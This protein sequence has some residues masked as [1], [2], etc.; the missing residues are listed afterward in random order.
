VLNQVLLIDSTSLD[1]SSAD[2]GCSPQNQCI[3]L[4]ALWSMVILDDITSLDR[5]K[6]IMRDKKGI[7]S[8]GLEKDNPWEKGNQTKDA[9]EDSFSTNLAIQ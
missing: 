3:S 4:L 1:C 6:K 7:T 9:E 5:T 8:M 2:N